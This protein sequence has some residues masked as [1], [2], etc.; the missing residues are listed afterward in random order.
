MNSLRNIIKILFQKTKPEQL[1]YLYQSGNLRKLP[2]FENYDQ[3]HFNVLGN[4]TIPYLSK[5][6]VKCVE[7]L[8][9]S[10]FKIKSE[11]E[12]THV[13]DPL[14]Y[15]AQEVLL[16][17]EGSP[18]IKYEHLLRWRETTHLL[19]EDLVTTAFMAHVDLEQT[20]NR[21][22]FSWR[23]IVPTDNV[24]LSNLLKKGVAENHFHLKG[25]A[26]HFELSWMAVMNQLTGWKKHFKGDADWFFENS[27]QVV[28][29]S[30]SMQGEGFASGA[31]KVRKA[32]VIRIFLHRLLNASPNGDFSA[33]QVEWH[34]IIQSDW[35]EHQYLNFAQSEIDLEKYEAFR[36]AGS[37]LSY[38]CPDYALRQKPEDCLMPQNF[39]LTGERAFLY[40]IFKVIFEHDIGHP[41]W[42]YLDLFYLYLLIKI[43]FRQ[44]FIQ[45]NEKIGFQNFADYQDRKGCF[46]PKG[47]T[48]EAAMYYLAVNASFG[49]QRIV[50]F[51]ARI[52]P[53]VSPSQLHRTLCQIDHAVTQSP[54]ES[55]HR[56]SDK[57]EQ[58]VSDELLA[59]M[60]TLL[61][62]PTA[63]LKGLVTTEG[64]AEA[65]YPEPT[66]DDFFYTIHFIKLFEDK[67]WG[68]GHLSEAYCR[69]YDMRRTVKKQAQAL[70]KLR[71]SMSKKGLR[72]LGID[73]ANSEFACRPEVYAQAFRFLK[74][75]RIS[76]K[77][78]H[79]DIQH[80]KV[81]FLRATFHAGEDFYDLVDGL[82]TIDEAIRFLDLRHGDR[83][84]HAMALGLHVKSFYAL[85][86]GMITLP[87]QVLLDNLA[88]L[89]IRVREYQIQDYQGVCM[90]LEQCFK[91]LFQE[92]YGD[93]W[94][95]APCLS[96][97]YD[98]WLLRADQPELYQTAIDTFTE[99][100][101]ITYWE[102]CRLSE[103]KEVSQ[104]RKTSK[105]AR[106]LYQLYHYSGEAKRKGAEIEEFSV[107]R[108]YAQLIKALQRAMALEIERKHLGIE[109][110][111]SSNLLIGPFNRYDEH[112]MLNLYNRGLNGHDDQHAQL[113]V[114]INT[115]DQGVFGTYLENE[116]AVM[117][118]ALEKMENE[119]GSP[120][121]RP[122]AIYDWLDRVR[123]MGIEQSFKQDIQYD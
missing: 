14:R 59:N 34:Q 3:N 51:E 10:K 22:D 4:E 114:S 1:F 92:L 116:Y 100:Q 30:T 45:V 102:R 53:Q 49:N 85:K 58:A 107:P 90:R 75:H 21:T 109:C 120:K 43:E 5:D 15:F 25:S 54:F 78:A 86:Q 57:K 17:K 82:R 122:D 52:A 103:D 38:P 69:N 80:D 33:K 44:E 31:D 72:V 13:F 23:P 83:L 40:Q 42:Q 110:N 60:A 61:N 37:K 81:P 96:T 91:H 2:L 106:F 67:K 6:E 56:Y 18:V 98:A 101:N 36:Y 55:E 28:G 35:N 39:I 105:D 71:D 48:Y 76:G 9:R 29:L 74:G 32:G 65:E 41:V 95:K 27:R 11:K 50:S 7:Q 20:R 64:M 88:W 16:K 112:P 118:K 12:P 94:T 77:F 63:S 93:E 121:Y 46:L 79:F 66:L 47:S 68:K 117:A 115:D 70:A 104:I 123:Q 87:K 26:P 108:G 24:R 99:P 111:P 97:Y 84:G 113:F 73:A 19:G 119:D 89:L 8:F 62:V